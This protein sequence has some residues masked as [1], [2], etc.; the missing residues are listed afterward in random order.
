VAQEIR[1]AGGEAQVW[2]A[3]GEPPEQ[4]A[5]LVALFVERA[6][7]DYQEILRALD[8]PARS[9][10]ELARLF[11]RVR[12]IDYFQAPSGDLARARLKDLDG[13]EGETSYTTH[14]THTNHIS[15]TGGG[16][17]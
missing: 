14:T 4:D 7:R 11:R 12:A 5:Q 13:A 6:E 8:D 16:T 1:E 17:A 9:R 15:H 10:T 3:Y 2:V